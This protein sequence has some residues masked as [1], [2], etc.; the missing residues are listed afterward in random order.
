M[1]CVVI[2]GVLARVISQAPAN[3][4][5]LASSTASYEGVEAQPAPCPPPG[6]VPLER[7]LTVAYPERTYLLADGRVCRPDVAGRSTDAR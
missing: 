6:A 3:D 2:I 7:D 5:P 1:A 4:A